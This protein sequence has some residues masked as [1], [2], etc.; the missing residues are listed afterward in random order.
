MF[1][2]K[3]PDAFIAAAQGEAVRGFGMREKRA[4]EIQAE[5]A[6]FGPIHPGGEMFGAERIAL[7]GLAVRFRV[8]GVEIAAMFAGDKLQGLVDIGAQFV[9]IACFS[10]IIAGGLDAAAGQAQIVLETADVV[11]LPA[12]ERDGDAA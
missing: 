4:I 10:R 12:M 11:S 1:D 8:N 5:T 6:L 7:D 3:L 9:G 2:P